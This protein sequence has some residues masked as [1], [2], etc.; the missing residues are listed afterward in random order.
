MMTRLV[1]GWFALLIVA[2]MWT[3]GSAA[4]DPGQRV[5]EDKC[6][7]CHGAN[8]RGG[9]GPGLVPFEWSYEQALKMIREPECDM[10]PMSA[11]EISDAQV[12]QLVAYLKT[13]K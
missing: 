8:A 11:S 4:D 9:K 2:S 7:R 12:A 5:Y 10:P 1:S 6:S 13:I 3:V